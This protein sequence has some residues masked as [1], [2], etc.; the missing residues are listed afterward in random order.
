[1]SFLLVNFHVTKPI[2]VKN[3]VVRSVVYKLTDTTRSVT[4]TTIS[5][6]LINWSV[7][8]RGGNT[9]ST[10]SPLTIRLLV[11][12]YI[13][14]F[15]TFHVFPRHLSKSKGLTSPSPFPVSSGIPELH[16]TFV[17]GLL[18]FVYY[19]WYPCLFLHHS[20]FWRRDLFLLL[21]SGLSL[22]ALHLSCRPSPVLVQEGG[23][24]R[25]LLSANYSSPDVKNFQVR[26]TIPFTPTFSTSD[27]RPSGLS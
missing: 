11:S 3:W 1:M 4:P 26:P 19:A 20:T 5:E 24:L 7:W 13:V 23:T 18:R 2:W 6:S 25:F 22:T 9:S 8:T 17:S 12:A 16:C 15:D 21:F 14:M 10:K 27:L